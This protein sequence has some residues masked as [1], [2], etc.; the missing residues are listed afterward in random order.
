VE[1][2]PARELAEELL[3]RRERLIEACLNEAD[4]LFAFWPEGASPAPRLAV[5]T[6]LTLRL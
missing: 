6:D 2:D 5:G 3:R 4:Q 1:S